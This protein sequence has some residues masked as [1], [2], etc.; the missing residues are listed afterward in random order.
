MSKK[1]IPPED[2]IVLSPV[3]KYVIYGKFPYFMIIH[4]LLLVFNTLQ[5]TI[6]ISEFNEYFRAQEKSFL[7]TL[8]STSAKEKRDYP[9]KTYLYT[10]SEL[11]KHLNDSVSKMFGANNSLFNTIIYMDENK[12]E[13]EAKSFTMKVKYKKD[14]N[15]MNHTEY[16]M[17]LK[18]FYQISQNDLGPLNSNYSDDDIKKYI[19]SVDLIG[20]KYYLKTYIKRD[21]KNYKECFI[22]DIIQMYDFRR[23]AHITVGLEIYNQ[24]CGVKTS[25]SRLEN[26]L[27]S[28]M[29]IHFVVFFLAIVS[30]IFCLYSFHVVNKLKRYK[31]SLIEKLKGK[32]IKNP[33]ILKEIETIEK[34]SKIWEFI[35]IVSNIF[36]ILGSFGS[37]MQQQ[38]MN[39]ATNI[40][41][42]FGI[43]LCYI[44]IGKYMDYDVNHALFFRSLSNLRSV[45]FPLIKKK[46]N[47][48]FSIK[49]NIY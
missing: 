26:I 40:V 37:L 23:K 42:A 35:L 41:I 20:I 45:L 3:E 16:P 32:K 44:S 12:A 1:Q 13:I 8:V 27:I 24:Q 7:N 43:L 28:H 49:L 22:W 38:N 21:F 25:F 5:V 29:W 14:L 10:I 17:Q 19:K 36:Q 34:A 30:V 47:Y 2:K 4:I 18:R 33:K 46:F 15:K 48:L 31:K 9:K 11:Q 39:Y 6:I